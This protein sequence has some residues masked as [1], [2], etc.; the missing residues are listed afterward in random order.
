MGQP[1][2]SIHVLIDKALQPASRHSVPT[3]SQ[4]TPNVHP[5]A[6][7]FIPVSVVQTSICIPITAQVKGYWSV[8][9]ILWNLGVRV[10]VTKN[11]G[12]GKSNATD[13]KI[14]SHT[15]YTSCWWWLVIWSDCFAF[16]ELFPV[17]CVTLAHTF[18]FF[19]DSPWCTHQSFDACLWY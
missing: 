5:N 6:C 18:F 3:W 7:N 16:R 11:Y 8:I 19:F 14:H 2:K 13:L 17:M 4:N 9:I 12:R 15:C 10:S 1:V